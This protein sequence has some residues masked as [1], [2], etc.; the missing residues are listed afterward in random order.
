VT[1]CHQL[2]LLCAKKGLTAAYLVKTMGIGREQ[3][4]L[5]RHYVQDRLQPE[6]S[7]EKHLDEAMNWLCRAQDVCGTT[8]VSAVFDLK[9]GWDVAYPE[10]SGYII[11]TYLAYADLSGNTSFFDRAL[12]I[13]N[14]EIDI[15]TPGGGVLSNPRYDYTRVFNTGQVILGWC[16]LFERTQDNKYLHAALRAG[17]YL[18]RIQEPDGSWRRDTYCGARTYHARVDWSLL[19]LTQVSGDERFAGAAANNLAWVLQQQRKNGWFDNCGFNNDN[20]I[21]HVIVYTLRGLLESYAIAT[22]LPKNLDI[23]PKII[24]AADP[25]CA[26]VER[27]CVKNIPLMIPTSFDENWES[28]DQHSCLTGN[29]QLA[30]FLFRL[31]TITKVDR[32]RTLAENVVSTLKKTHVI[33]TQFGQ[34]RG[35]ISGTFPLYH[36]YHQNSYPNWATK[37]FADALM[38][39]L[40]YHQQIQI[41]A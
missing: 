15:Q 36:G 37:F 8:G 3:L 34:I 30:C 17:D 20:P 23:L 39:K 35:A 22:L 33:S 38:M 11:A 19:R 25:L 24:R 40:R 29:A 31:S 1:T 16:A 5:I 2:P 10:T 32:Y 41:C 28:S 4:S 27:N 21:M 26:A 18:M 12:R 14:W 7:D 6:H 13:G 9:K